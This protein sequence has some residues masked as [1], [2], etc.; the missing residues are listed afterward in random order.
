MLNRVEQAA[1]AGDAVWGGLDCDA[2][3]G[4]LGQRE[5]VRAVANMHPGGQPIILCREERRDHNEDGRAVPWS[6]RPG[7]VCPARTD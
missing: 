6:A 1:S 5:L 4:Y 2:Q 3:K 7:R